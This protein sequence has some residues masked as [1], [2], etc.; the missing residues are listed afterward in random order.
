MVRPF[1]FFC[2]WSCVC[3]ANATSFY[4]V[5]M[6]VFTHNQALSSIQEHVT[7][8]LSFTNNQNMIS[9]KPQPQH[10]QEPFCL[11]PSSS[12]L[13]KNEYWTLH[14]QPEYKVL[15]HYT[16]LQ[17]QNSQK[18]I[19]IPVLDQDGWNI[20]GTINI[21]KGMYYSLNTELLFTTHQ[22]KK[23]TFVVAQKQQL[24]PDM[25]YYLDD[26]KAGMLV[27]IHPIA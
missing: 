1:V 20:Q 23:N 14:H 17:P 3:D 10:P 19:A 26:A 9:L 24:K 4:Q 21:K 16:W 22:D 15:M 11:L 25:L 13:L 27:K 12:S 5:D 8:S 6:I 2:L 18:T 7:P